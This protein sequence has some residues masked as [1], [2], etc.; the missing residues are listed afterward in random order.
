MGQIYEN[1]LGVSQDFPK[2]FEF[3]RKSADHK[4]ADAQYSVGGKTGTAQVKGKADHSTFVLFA[5]YDNPKIAISVVLEHGASGYAS[6]TLV[7]QILDSY[8]FSSDNNVSDIPPFTV[9]E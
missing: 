2:A 3:Y 6:G 1:G 4:N 5:P 9:L 7:R 8:F